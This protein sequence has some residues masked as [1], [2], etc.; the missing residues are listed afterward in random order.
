MHG[1]LI[2]FNERLHRALVAKEA[3][4]SQMR[5]ELIDLRGPVSAPTRQG[6]GLAIL[7]TPSVGPPSLC[8]SQPCCYVCSMSRVWKSTDT[9]RGSIQV[10]TIQ[11]LRALAFSTFAFLW[12]GGGKVNKMLQNLS[13]SPW[14]H[15]MPCTYN[16]YSEIGIQPSP[17][18]FFFFFKKEFLYFYYSFIYLFLA[19]LGLRF[20]ARA[21]SSCRKQGSLF[22]AVHG[23][24]LLRSTDSRRAGSV[25]V[26]HG[27]SCSTA[28]G[29]FPDQG[30]N[31]CPLHWQADSQPL[32]HQGSPVHYI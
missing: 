6:P 27:P 31:P 19:V 7:P 29:I 20:C 12:V 13:K 14:H 10:A 2:E 3:L 16:R 24:L 22:I 21:F 1:E 23:P 15:F 11:I 32:R 4:V 5:Q 30:S 17:P 9:K 28:C 25:I 8:C 18:C 26:A